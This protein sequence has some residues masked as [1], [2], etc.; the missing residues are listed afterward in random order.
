MEMRLSAGSIPRSVVTGARTYVLVI[1]C[2]AFSACGFFPVNAFSTS[3]IDVLERA[4]KPP[5]FDSTFEGCGEAGSQPDY[6]LNRLKNRV[7]EGAYVPVPWKLIARLPWPRRVGYR[8]RNQWSRSETDEVARL[9]GA[10]VELEGH[11]S[12][13]KLEFPEP[14]NCYAT[15]ERRRDFH[16]WLSEGPYDVGKRSIVVELTPRVRVTHVGWTEERLAALVSTQAR[17]RLRGWLMLDQMH[18]ESIGWSRSSLWEVHPVM[19]IEW[20]TWRGAW[21]SLDS[22]SPASDSGYDR[23]PSMTSKTRR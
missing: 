2:T 23:P 12:D 18:P 16:L 8:F 20:R 13:Y 5:P 10:A 22:L 1:A 3:G 21:V 6:K 15:D 11:L 7:D 17:V 4:P 19:H 14:P 9:E